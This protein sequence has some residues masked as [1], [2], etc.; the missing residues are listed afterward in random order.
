M[1]HINIGG[2]REI[3]ED[4]NAQVVLLHPIFTSTRKI[5][6]EILMQM[7]G[8]VKLDDFLL[9]V[10]ASNRTKFDDFV[11]KVVLTDRN[12]SK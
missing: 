9:Y 11:N 12:K 4:L 7:T 6:A 10:Q 3:I 8:H 2:C 1:H 5:Q